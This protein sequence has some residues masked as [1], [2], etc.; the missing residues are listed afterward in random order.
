VKRLTEHYSRLPRN[1]R[2]ACWMLGSA[3]C[4][5]VMTTLVKYLGTDYSAS[6]QTFYRQLFTLLAV[7]PLILKDPRRVLY[8]PRPG[9]LLFRAITSVSGITLAFYSYQHMPLADANALSFTRTLWVIPLAAFVL[10][11]RIGPRRIAALS[12]GFAGVLLILQP[13][14]NS[15]FAISQFSWPAIAALASALLLATTVTGMKLLTHDHSTT[16]L[17]SWAAILGTLASLPPALLSWRWPGSTDL[18][19]LASMGLFGALT[20]VCYMKGMANGDAALMAPLDYM[21]LVFAVIAGLVL[22]KHVPTLMTIAGSLIIMASTLYITFS[23]I[24][25]DIAPGEH[26]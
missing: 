18:L 13:N 7:L 6:L 26:S 15:Q 4:F 22:F 1:V 9:L 3:A 8:S 16:T 10:H 24:A 11:E 19:L 5:T 17:L 23:E 2:G 25:P 21:R 20:Q 12:V 14:A